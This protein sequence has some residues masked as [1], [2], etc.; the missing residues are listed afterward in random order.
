MWSGFTEL[1]SF[2]HLLQALP[3]TWGGLALRA[4]FFWVFRA[5]IFLPIRRLA[6]TS[7]LLIEFLLLLIP[8]VFLVLVSDAFLIVIPFI[9]SIIQPVD[10]GWFNFSQTLDGLSHWVA[11][12]SIEVDNQI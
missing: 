5:W 7:L 4:Q 12:I 1:I 8:I 10:E 11:N 2:S 9:K 3:K 6:I